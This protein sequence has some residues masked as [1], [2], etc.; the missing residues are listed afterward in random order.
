MHHYTGEAIDNFSAYSLL[1]SFCILA[2]K[3]TTFGGMRVGIVFG[4]QWVKMRRENMLRRRRMREVRGWTLDFRIRYGGYTWAYEHAS[5]QWDTKEA[6]SLG[7]EQTPGNRECRDWAITYLNQTS[8]NYTS[9]PFSHISYRSPSPDVSL[10]I[11]IRY[12]LDRK[13]HIIKSV[14]RVWI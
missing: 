9:I 3:R 12:L 6:Y 4:A 11:F 13:P 2:R 10:S 1:T 8:D 5:I 14:T 7:G